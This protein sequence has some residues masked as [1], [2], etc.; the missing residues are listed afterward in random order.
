[1]TETILIILG[2]IVF[3]V[4]LLIGLILIPLGLSGTF[5]IVGD[6]L[7]FSLFDKFDKIP[8]WVIIVFFIV[9]VLGEVVEYLSSVVGTKKFGASNLSI[10]LMFV[11]MIAGGLIG[12]S[13]TFGIGAMFGAIIGAFIGA[14][15]GELI[16]KKNLTQALKAGTGAFLGKMTAWIV[17][18]SIGI[19]MVV[20]SVIL[21]WVKF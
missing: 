14:L 4:V 20:I 16:S 11:F 19:V 2:Y 3:H 10:V 1:M 18:V 8:I 21:I 7:V 12:A 6:V 5:I 15:V 13:F 17:K 9:S